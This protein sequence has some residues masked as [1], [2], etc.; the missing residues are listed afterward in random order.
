MKESKMYRF[1]KQPPRTGAEFAAQ[2]HVQAEIARRE[3]QAKQ[4]AEAASSLL[5]TQ[6]PTLPVPPGT[7][8]GY[9]PAGQPKIG[10]YR[11]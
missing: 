4:Q 7:F 6:Q 2:P 10:T 3:R 8:V 5:N 11:R 1:G 9:R